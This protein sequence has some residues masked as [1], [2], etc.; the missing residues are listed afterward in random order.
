[1]TCCRFFAR[2]KIDEIGIVGVRLQKILLFLVVVNFLNLF[3]TG[4]LLFS[5][6]GFIV[7]YIGFVGALR[8]NERLLR[9]YYVFNIVL[10]IFA[11]VGGLL[12]A[13][14]T[15]N[16]PVPV[17]EGGFEEE[18]PFSPAMPISNNNNSSVEVAVPDNN[19][20]NDS[21]SNNAVPPMGSSTDYSEDR[22]V[23]PIGFFFCFIFGIVVFA[24]KISSI[25]LAGRMSRMLR[26]R[27]LHNL[28]H[29]IAK[30]S[31]NGYESVPQTPPEEIAAPPAV[32]QVVYIQMPMQMP[33]GYPFPQGFAPQYGFVPQPYAPPMPP[34]TPPS[35]QPKQV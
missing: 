26:E 2:Q 21:D 9:F 30:K 24:F 1:M 32:P 20:S 23:F 11:L 7:L 18:G 10:L 22:P 15:L 29:P 27:N 16:H 35:I 4:A 12:F 25:I 33:Q 5:L 34:T 17:D 31:N 13:L 14:Y 6:F 19:S 28:A 3:H 8:R